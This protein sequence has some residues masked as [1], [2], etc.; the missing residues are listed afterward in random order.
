MPNVPLPSPRKWSNLTSIVRS[1]TMSWVRLVMKLSL[2]L[3]ELNMMHPGRTAL[4]SERSC[5]R[6]KLR[7]SEGVVEDVYSPARHLTQHHIL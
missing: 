6:I 7:R 4:H 5:R 1:K 3:S 2:L